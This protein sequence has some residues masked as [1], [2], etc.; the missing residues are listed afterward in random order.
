MVT[1]SIA[2]LGLWTHALK[3]GYQGSARCTLVRVCHQ[4]KFRRHE[5][6]SAQYR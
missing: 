1:E 3:A 4:L 2:V 6:L 5:I